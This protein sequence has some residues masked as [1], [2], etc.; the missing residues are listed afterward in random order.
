MDNVNREKQY[1]TASRHGQ[2]VED[3]AD[4]ARHR[5]DL[6]HDVPSLGNAAPADEGWLLRQSIDQTCFAVFDVETTGLQPAYGHRICEIACLRLHGGVEV[7]RFESLVDPGRDISPG[8][9]RINHITPQMLAGAPVFGTVAW[10]V[11]DLMEGAVLVAHNAP[12]DLGFLAS[13]LDLAGLPAPGGPVVDTLALSRRIYSFPRNSLSAVADSLGVEAGPSHRAMGD[14]LTTCQV[15]ERQL[16]DLEK[17]YGVTTLGELVAFQ[18]GS[19]AYPQPNLIPLPPGIAEAL[20][21][22]AR[23]WLRYVDAQGQETRRRIRPLTVREHK[24]QL[25][26]IAHCYRAG[27]IR[28]FR[29]D[30]VVEMALEA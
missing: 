29:L 12:F 19:V 27:A 1:S 2:A 26:L 24:G 3:P 25:L 18:G 11:L 14:V 5:Q 10:P 20:D 30:R 8:A 16:W 23:V 22:R 21:T 6:V 4:C 9:Y 15:L 13:E 7:G 28:T 17:R